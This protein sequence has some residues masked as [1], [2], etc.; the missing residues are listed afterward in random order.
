MTRF[1]VILVLIVLPFTRCWTAEPVNHP[2][3]L[4]IP[5]D[6]ENPILADGKPA[7]GKAVLQFLPGSAGT[8]VIGTLKFIASNC[9]QGNFTLVDLSWVNPGS[10][11]L[12]RDTPERRKI[13]QWLEEIVS[14]AQNDS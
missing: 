4:T 2:D 13:R 8:E 9:P 11:V 7:P 1:V 6:L 5:A 12:L 14:H 10:K 3:V